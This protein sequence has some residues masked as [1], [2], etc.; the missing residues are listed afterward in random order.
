MIAAVRYSARS[1]V[2]ISI[3]FVASRA[4]VYIGVFTKWIFSLTGVRDPPHGRLGWKSG[5]KLECNPVPG[6]LTFARLVLHRS[7]L[8]VQDLNGAIICDQVCGQLLARRRLVSDGSSGLDTG[9]QE[10]RGTLTASVM[11]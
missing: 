3:K 2:W 5:I 1:A 7:S 4:N 11:V 8:F 9:D 6:E 10:V